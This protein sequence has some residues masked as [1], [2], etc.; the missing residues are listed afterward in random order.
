MTCTNQQNLILLISN[1]LPIT[2]NWGL[3]DSESY[4][5]SLILAFC[6][7]H[8]S[9][10]RSAHHRKLRAFSFQNLQKSQ[11][12]VPWRGEKIPLKT[13]Y[14]YL[15]TRGGD[16]TENSRLPRHLLG[17]L[18]MNLKIKT[19]FLMNSFNKQ[20]LSPSWGQALCFGD[21]GEEGEWQG[22]KKIFV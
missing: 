12:I 13:T 22:R 8:S 17:Y 21:A 5:K 14:P 7:H 1:S 3:M 11:L 6:D 2:N 9:Y 15:T 16:A 10:W 19:N 20:A 18:A 4:S